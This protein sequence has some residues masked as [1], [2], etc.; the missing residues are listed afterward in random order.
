MRVGIVIPPVLFFMDYGRFFG[1]RGL[2]KRECNRGVLIHGWICEWIYRLGAV[3]CNIS[4][5]DSF[6]LIAFDQIMMVGRDL[7]LVTLPWLPGSLAVDGRSTVH[8][9]VF[10]WTRSWELGWDGHYNRML[11][12]ADALYGSLYTWGPL[13]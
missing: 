4:V 13:Y 1:T 10:G 3:K 9:G 8:G 7:L 6:D 5:C 2:E 12:V 11:E